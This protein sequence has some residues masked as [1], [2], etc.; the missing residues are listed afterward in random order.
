MQRVLNEPKGIN[1]TNGWLYTGGVGKVDEDGYLFLLDR[2]KEM[3]IR[4]G[5]ITSASR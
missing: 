2:K 5:R 1:I 3:I 4:T